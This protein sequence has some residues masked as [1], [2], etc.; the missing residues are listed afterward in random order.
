MNSK[1]PKHFH[2]IGIS[3]KNADLFTRGKFNLNKLQTNKLL[4]KGKTS[5]IEDLLVLSTCNRTEIYGMVYNPSELIQ[6]LCEFSFGDEKKFNFYGYSLKNEKAFNHLFRVGTGLESQILGDFEIIGQIKKSFILSKIQNIK[7]TFLERFINYVIQAS[8]KIKNETKISS[9]ATSI[10]F[11]SV[12]FILNNT[13]NLSNKKILLFGTGKIGKNTCENLLKHTNN[14]DIVLI[15]RTKEKAEEIGVKFNV[16]VKEYGSL[17]T[18]ISSSDILIV[19][20]SAKKPTIKKDLIFNS[21]PIMILDLSIPNNVDL[22]VK[23]LKN[24]TLV[25][26]DELSSITN[27]NLNKRK[28]Y[29]PH[30]EKIIE[31]LLSEFLQWSHQRKF[32]PALKAFKTKLTSQQNTKE[33]SSEMIEK[34][35]GQFATYLKEN[36][37]KVSETINLMQNVF[38]LDIVNHE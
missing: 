10:S 11:A 13:K 33:I 35:T 12:Q 36:P 30:A 25:N 5:G 19:A 22:N 15:N 6:L 8:K 26:L 28:K 3:Y 2:V 21:N 34:L 9:G 16:K 31:E 14:A 38:E 7:I 18:E 23:E 4:I 1:S 24:V 32:A 20:T 29:I 37:S 17:P 27:K